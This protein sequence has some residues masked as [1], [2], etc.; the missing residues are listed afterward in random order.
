MASEYTKMTGDMEPLDHFAFNRAMPE[1][2]DIQGSPTEWTSTQEE[3]D[4]KQESRQKAAQQ[5]QLVDAAPA[6]A[7]VAKANPQGMPGK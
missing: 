7:S 2:L 6:L 1:I 5:Q 4:A 3:I